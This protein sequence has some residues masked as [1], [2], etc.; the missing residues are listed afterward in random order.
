MKSIAVISTIIILLFSA[1]CTTKQDPLAITGTWRLL[2]GTLIE[3]G[4]TTV[5]DYTTNKQFIK[6]INDSHFAFMSHDLNKGK[7]SATAS[8]SAGGGK[9]SL[10]DST[11]T[12]H[13]EYCNARDW[14]NNDFSFTVSIHNDTL[15]QQGVEKIEGTNINRLNIEKYVRLRQGK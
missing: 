2:T 6:I 11:Y 10:K 4:D 3:K 7:D 13:L 15:I 5:T 14:E 9:Y 1:S 12:E 8:F